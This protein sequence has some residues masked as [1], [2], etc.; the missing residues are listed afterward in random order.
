[1]PG[2]GVVGLHSK[3]I[4]KRGQSLVVGGVKSGAWIRVKGLCR[5]VGGT[6]KEYNS[7]T[8]ALDVRTAV[9]GGG[10]GAS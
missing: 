3:G 6:N 9:R 4:E 10:G 8:Q 2:G 5:G 1:V 7:K